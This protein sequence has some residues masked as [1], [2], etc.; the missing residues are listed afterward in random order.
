MASAAIERW[1]EGLGA[2]A[3]APGTA[4]EYAVGELRLLIMA[5]KLGPGDR[6]NQEDL[7]ARVG[8]SVAPVREA[9]RVLE[10]EGQLTYR[11]RRGYFVTELLIEDLEEIYGLRRVLE[12]R[13]AREALPFIDQGS[14][15]LIRMAAHECESAAE[16]ANVAAQLNANRRFHFGILAT[17]SRPQTMRL[18]R[19]LWDSTEG[20][21]A[22]YY[23][24]PEERRLS[25]RA[26]ERILGALEARDPERLVGE[27]DRHRER[28][29]EVLRAVLR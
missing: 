23:N 16:T 25:L 1:S 13:A 10:G 24:S 3:P 6:V 27:L 14:I 2:R 26:H 22:L 18:I 28:A 7:A 19:L 5:G 17:P 11:P 21:R 9:L 29:L 20:Y 15:S 8:L 4:Q 12:G